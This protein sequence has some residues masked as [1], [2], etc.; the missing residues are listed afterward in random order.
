MSKRES[1][2]RYNL[3][4]KKLRNSPASFDEI[5]DY[6]KLESEIQSYDFAVS[7]RTFQRDLDDIRSIY[8]IDIKFSF[9]EGKYYIASDDEGSGVT[10][11]ILEAF[12]TF[13]AL[14]IADR[15]SGYIHFNRRRS[16][17]T[18]YL[19]GLLHAIKNKLQI[20]FT[21][22]KYYDGEISRRVTEPYALK[23]SDHR[24]Y[25]LAY[26][27][28]DKIVKSFA[29]DRL[30]NLDITRRP[31]QFPRSFDVNEYYRYCFGIISSGNRSPQD[32]VLKFD[33][34]QGKYIKSLPIHESQK[35]ISEEGGLTIS[36]KLVL[37][38]DF[39]MELLSYGQNVKV[40]KPKK[41]AD[42]ICE[43]YKEALKQYQ[44]K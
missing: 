4:I 13:N 24:W 38:Y 6:L 3:I 25:L 34:L 40:L 9:T 31:F 23:E 29:L 10:D 12:D 16:S 15:L 7:K 39:V 33:P 2:S 14:N 21:Y 11:R 32:I 35:V 44:G 19:Y 37:T 28:R 20:T 22:E 41:L 36:L 27:L 1:I 18:E 5:L 30:S 17:G 42:K 8:N 43:I 26:D